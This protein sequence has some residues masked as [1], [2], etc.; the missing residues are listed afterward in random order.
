MK[1]TFPINKFRELR[2]P[3]YYYDTKVLRDTLDCIRTEAAKYGNYSVHYAVKA[4]ANPKVLAIIREN[5]LGADCVSG[6]EIR[7]AIKPVFPLARL[8]LPGWVRLIGKLIWGW[9]MIF[10]ALMWSL[11]LSWKLSMSWLPLKVR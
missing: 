3:F 6:G 7:A 9:I 11:S 2:T 1:G 5:G 10:S 4:N 8:F